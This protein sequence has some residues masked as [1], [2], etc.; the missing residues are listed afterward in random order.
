M[1]EASTLERLLPLACLAAAACLF[2]SEL[3]TAFE[4]TPEGAEPISEQENHDRHGW[5][6]AVLA[7]FA[8]L[9]LWGVVRAGSKPAAIAVAACGGIAL[10]MFLLLDLPDAGNIGSLEDQGTIGLTAEAVPQEGFWLE[11]LGALGLAIGGAALATMTPE[12][13]A[14]LAVGRRASRRARERPTTGAAVI[15]QAE[16]LGEEVQEERAAA[17]G[18]PG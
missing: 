5:A 10:L 8:I 9:S 2:A 7:V 4:F 15:D 1:S 12:Q 6:L 18:E 14:A 16:K 3:M 11:L 17:R 13:L